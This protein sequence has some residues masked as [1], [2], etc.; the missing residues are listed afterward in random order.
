MQPAA[1]E[2]LPKVEAEL[3]DQ[4]AAVARLEAENE[5]LRNE[6]GAAAPAAGVAGPVSPAADAGAEPS[7]P[8]D[9]SHAQA[10][11]TGAGLF[12]V[13]LLLGLLIPLIPRGPRRNWSQL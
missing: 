3:A 10:M 5:L 9:Q 7:V 12:V 6:K 13:G 8:A 1:R 2:R 11:F 4:K